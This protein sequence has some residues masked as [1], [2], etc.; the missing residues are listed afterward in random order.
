MDAIEL[1]ETDE[2]ENL[3]AQAQ[4]FALVDLVD[5]LIVDARDF[6]DGGKRNGEQAT[7]DAEE[8][9]LNAGQRE[10][11]AELDVGAF[12]FAG[13]DVD[14]A[15]KAIKD[16]ADNV[17]ANPAAGNFG[18]FAGGAETR[19]EN[20]VHDVLIREASGVVCFDDA[21]ADGVLADVIKVNAAAVVAD[22]DDDL[23]ALMVG[24]E[25]NGAA[26]GLAGAETF[27]GGLDAVVDGVADEVS[28]RLR[29]RV[30]DALVEIGV[31]AGD[32]QGDVFA[33]EF[34]DVANDAR[35]T[36]KELLDRH[37]ADF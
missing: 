26:R 6:D 13:G 22:F 15:L 17:H 11:N 18:D 7:S 8:K 30:E 19:F 36:A 5:F 33:A 25:R 20:Q 28:E 14:R 24:V 37:H 35:K 23:G 34:C 9:R 10:R 2:G 3:I 31:F 12:A 16:G 4:D 32:F 27:V 1:V 21:V 29:E